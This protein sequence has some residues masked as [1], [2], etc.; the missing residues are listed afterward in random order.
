MSAAIP[1][2]VAAAIQT[3]VAY[4]GLEQDDPWKKYPAVLQV[5]HVAEILGVTE[6]AVRLQCR[7]G[8]RGSIPM[9]KTRCGYVIDQVVFRRWAGYVDSAARVAG[10]GA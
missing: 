7:R 1:A 9:V 6:A 3:L 2:G 4:A 8:R 5:K 10:G